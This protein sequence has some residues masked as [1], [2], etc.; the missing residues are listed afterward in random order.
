MSIGYRRLHLSLGRFLDRTSVN[1]SGV[2]QQVRELSTRQRT[3][4]NGSVR[5]IF[6]G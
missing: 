2:L 6:A 4:T 3:L 5:G 1:Y